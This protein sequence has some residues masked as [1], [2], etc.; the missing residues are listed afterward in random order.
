[1]DH[2]TLWTPGKDLLEHSGLTDYMH[3]L[4]THRGIR[5]TAY[6]DLWNWSVRDPEAFWGSFFDY[7]AIITHQPYTRVMQKPAQGMI[8]TR[9]FEGATVNYAEHIFRH[10]RPGA[11]AIVFRKEDGKERT[12]DWE[13][14]R[15]QTAQVAAWLTRQG[16][17][18]GDRVASVLPNIPE[19]VVA[20]L[21]AQ[22][23]GAVWS[24]CSPDFGNPSIEDRFVQIAPKVLFASDGYLYNGKAYSK[25]GA[26]Q[27]LLENLPSLEAVV[28]LPF[29]EEVP[30]MDGAVSWAE[31]LSGP[32]AALV[33]EPLP[34][35][36]PLWILYSSG[37]TGKPKAITHS[38]GGNL[39]EHLKVLWLHWDVKP[40]EKFFWYS[41]TG[42]MMWNFSVASLLAGATLV[43]YDGSAGHPSLDTL[44]K[45][46]Q[47][48]GIHHFGGGAAF[49]IACMKE[50]LGFQPG[51]FP[52][53]RTIG[54]TGSPLPAEAYE[55]IYEHVK[56]DVWLISFSGGTDICSG[57]VG[58]C[59][60]W[61]VVAGEIQCRLLGCYL[62]AFNEAGQPVRDELGEMVILEPMPSMPIYFWN[63][64]DNQR[65]RASYFE[66]YPGIWRHG[67]WIRISTRGSVV[68]YGRSDATL[69]RDG[70]RIGTAEVYSAVDAVPE[71]ADSLVVCVERDGGKYYMPL[72]VVMKQGYALTDEVRMALKKSLK[73]RYSPRHVP[74][75]I[76]EL[77]EIPYTISGKK[78]EAPVKK[79]LMGMDPRTVA[80]R[81]TMR[82]PSSLAQFSKLAD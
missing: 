51:D 41:T 32:Q 31:V 37:T 23:I 61:P 38:V 54:S 29:V 24:S 78:M 52:H 7:A 25:I 77:A 36:H 62:E 26:W 47:Q 46:A 8:G 64:V 15:S 22:S 27:L 70:V 1:M 21:A 6:E 68:I 76:I 33:F 11:P 81:D 55:W 16:V 56:R 75:E 17:G 60:H 49:F 34:F 57:F 30:V 18:K 5:Y 39:I 67:D 4:E 42:W 14:L 20:F 58:G 45:F 35:D 9:W 19:A 63:D 69:N 44:W 10:A 50:G 2:Q 12:L 72:Y 13:T 80:S 66:Q 73:D 40:G 48:Q 71:V 28:L 43:I 82:N 53:L 79:I 65:Y 3:W 59:P 74:D